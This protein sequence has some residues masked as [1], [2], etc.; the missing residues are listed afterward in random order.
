MR[1][2]K[3]TLLLAVIAASGMLVQGAWAQEKAKGR[4][5][6]QIVKQ[7]CSKCHQAGVNGAPK[8]GDRDAWI[9]RMKQG[10]DA[11]VQAAINGHGKMPARGGMAN[12]TDAELRSAIVYLVNAGKG[13]AK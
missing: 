9:P 7:Q 5:G 11:T 13:P 10:L 1:N 2:T 8:I 3:S 4:S 12:L 6:E